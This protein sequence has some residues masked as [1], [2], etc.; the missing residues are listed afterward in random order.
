M[1]K[2]K[3]KKKNQN[4]INHIMKKEFSILVVHFLHLRIL[5]QFYVH[6]EVMEKYSV[7]LMN[8]EIRINYQKVMNSKKPL[9]TMSMMMVIIMIKM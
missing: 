4:F 7:V 2:N 6:L 9:E 8:L 3:K 5:V 1:K